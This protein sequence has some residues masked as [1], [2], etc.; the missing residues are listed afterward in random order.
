M[1]EIKDEVVTDLTLQLT[2]KSERER[3]FTDIK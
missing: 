1:R 2:I 3:H